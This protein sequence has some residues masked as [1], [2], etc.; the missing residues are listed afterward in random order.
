MTAFSGFEQEDGL[1]RIPSRFFTDLL[2][3]IT[4][5]HELKVTLY[6]LWRIQQ[7]EGN[8]LYITDEEI[9]SDAAFVAGLHA[10]SE[11]AREGLKAALNQAVERGSLL[12]AEASTGSARSEVYF[13]NTERSR[14]AIEGLARGLWTLADSAAFPLRTQEERP[15]IFA[16][17]EENI[18]PLTPLIADNLADLSEE[19]TDQWVADALMIAVKN[20]ARR[21]AYIE[22]ILKRWQQ[23]GRGQRPA[24]E[25]N[26]NRFSNGKYG[27]E[28]E[29]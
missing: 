28:I 6:C 26:Y 16:L 2:P 8:L 23:D 5:I 18:G 11:N 17:Y 27:N 24:A 29:T 14:T 15:G 4:D 10:G 1:V 21:L 22:A 7:R 12:K 9:L 20:N 13:A 25:D 3:A 19:Y